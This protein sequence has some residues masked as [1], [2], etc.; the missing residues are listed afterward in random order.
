MGL[1]YVF[2]K[3][4][5]DNDTRSSISAR[6]L[7]TCES[8]YVADELFRDLQT[9]QRS[10]GRFR[11]T[12]LERKTPQ[13]WVYD[14]IDDPGSV[15]A[16]V[17]GTVLLPKF[18][19]TVMSVLLNDG[20]GRDWPIAPI[21]EGPDWV[22]GGSYFIRNKRQP[23]LYWYHFNGEIHVSERQKTKFRVIAVGKPELAKDAVL[24]G[25]DEVE[26]HPIETGSPNSMILYVSTG[27]ENI[28]NKLL[29]SGAQKSWKLNKLR[30][31]FGTTWE[32]KGGSESIQELVTWC[33][34]SNLE[35]SN[36]DH[37]ELC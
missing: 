8:R 16:D 30:D 37:W 17:L 1:Y 18:G 29:V 22:N 32:Q 24:I 23:N 28:S 12:R 31:S 36:A 4:K 2:M 35:N 15:L 34:P 7:L 25:S 26:I 10:D 33:D 9:V 5:R 21:V 14:T 19:S 20:G 3:W 11:F 27:G 6:I 13:F